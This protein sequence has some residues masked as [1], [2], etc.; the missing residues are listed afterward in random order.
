MVKN[1]LK[2]FK[3]KQSVFLQFCAFLLIL[4]FIASDAAAA[5][6]TYTF[7]FGAGTDKWAYMANL[8]ATPTTGPDLPGQIEIQLSSYTNIAT[9]DNVYYSSSTPA[10]WEFLHCKFTI[11]EATDTITQINPSSPK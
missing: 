9:S 10:D 7:S 11:L 8:S 2:T 3:K 5:V 1:G 4:F 6:S